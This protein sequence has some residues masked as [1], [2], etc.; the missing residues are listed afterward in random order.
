MNYVLLVHWMLAG[1]SFPPPTGLSWGD[2]QSTYRN[3]ELYIHALAFISAAGLL[4][5]YTRHLHVKE[6]PEYD[7]STAVV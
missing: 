5:I 7:R 1:L 3:W 6:V 2:V 4:V